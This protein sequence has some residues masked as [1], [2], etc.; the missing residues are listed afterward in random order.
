MLPLLYSV[1]HLLRDVTPGVLLLLGISLHLY[2]PRYRATLEER[3]KKRQVTEIGA[4]RALAF[5]R[6]SAP[7]LTVLGV[8]L[9]GS[10]IW[11]TYLENY[12]VD[13]VFADSTSAAVALAG[14]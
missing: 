13:A 6:W 8:V 9:L 12:T 5:V 2:L 4:R 10:L 7:T 3:I 11:G 14:P 1:H